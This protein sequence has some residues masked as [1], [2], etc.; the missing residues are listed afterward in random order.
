VTEAGGGAGVL[1]AEA[2]PALLARFK[3]PVHAV[4]ER[5]RE[6][7]ESADATAA[8]FA[9]LK[10]TLPRMPKDTPV[11]EWVYRTV[12]H[13]LRGETATSKLAIPR[14]L[15]DSL[16]ARAA[17]LRAA[18]A[19]LPPADRALFLLTRAA[20][21]PTHTAARAVGIPE[22]EAP[23][24]LVGVLESLRKALQPLLVLNSLTGSN[25]A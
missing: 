9:E 20:G 8:V 3:D 17:F 16:G 22:A 6:S 15:A 18:A 4:F 7:A 14:R 23:R 11:E 12:W 25:P 19:T 21:V 24:R 13:T 2:F 1:G 10:R 5:T